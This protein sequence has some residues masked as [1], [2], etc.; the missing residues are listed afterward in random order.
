MAQVFVRQQPPRTRIVAFAGAAFPDFIA[1]FAPAA[2]VPYLAD[3]ARLE[4]A[5]IESC[6]A[7]DAEPLTAETIG[8]ALADPHLLANMTITLHPSVRLLSSPYAI[9]SVWAAHQGAGELGSVDPMRPEQVLLFRD[10]LDVWALPVEAG[11]GYFL[12]QLHAGATLGQA[13]DAAANADPLDT[14][15]L[16][17]SIALLLRHPLVCQMESLP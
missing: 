15:D 7:A 3:V 10:G 16:A 4:M 9:H 13:A 2:T 17:G 1:T 8:R 14:F 5:R 12:A 6:H 11:S